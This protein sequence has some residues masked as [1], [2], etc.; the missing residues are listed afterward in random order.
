MA[1]LWREG[2]DPTLLRE[3][4]ARGA[5]LAIPTESSYGLAVDPRDAAGVAAI[6]RIK[7]REAGKSLLV[8]AADTAQ[9]ADLEIDTTSP[10][11][12]LGRQFWP[13]PL[14]VLLPLIGGRQ[15]PAMAGAST[16]ACRI[17]AHP[18]LQ[19]L[20]A[21]LACPLTATSANLAGEPPLLDPA[22]V[23]A[24]LSPFEAV[25]VDGGVLPG[26]PPSTLVAVDAGGKLDVLRAGAFPTWQLPPFV[27]TQGT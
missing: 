13:A 26:G 11:W 17:P 24:W 4:L 22:A 1:T 25:V 2:D 7:E 18:L 16:L 3:A 9:L 20:L 10:A 19:R 6:Y 14:T 5:V 27:R 23:A 12:Q 15:W 8:V 21:Q